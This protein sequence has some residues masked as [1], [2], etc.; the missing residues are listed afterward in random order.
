MIIVFFGPP[1]SGKGTQAQ[2][3]K[4]KNYNIEHIPMG[5]LLR[6]EVATC[7]RIG[8]DIKEIMNNG[9]LVTDNIILKL[10][11][12]IILKK[13]DKNIIFDGFP[14][15]LTQAIA[16]DDLLGVNNLKVDIVFDFKIDEKS[17]IER[18]SGRYACINC[19]T[20]YHSKNKMPV[21]EGICDHCGGFRFEKRNDDTAILLKKRVSLY[22]NDTQSFKNYY[23]N[24]H[25]LKTVDAS[26]DRFEVANYIKAAL[27]EAGLIL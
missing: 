13:T 27:I 3:L 8:Q 15:T 6:Q 4:K 9:E 7:T 18:I 12:D 10:I 23:A 14:R 1:G 24:K 5:E 22:N 2:E 11:H 26:L 16:F 20:V 19:G 21:Q 17:L 25:I